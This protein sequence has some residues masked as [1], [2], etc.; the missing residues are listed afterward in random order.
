MTSQSGTEELHHYALLIEEKIRKW[1]S[2]RGQM[3]VRRGQNEVRREVTG[4]W[5]GQWE[6]LEVRRWTGKGGGDWNRS[7][8]RRDNWF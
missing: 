5:E 6:G 3:V 7:R 8:K 2:G 4:E 1:K